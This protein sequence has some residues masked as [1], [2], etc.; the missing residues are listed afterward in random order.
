LQDGIALAL[1]IKFGE[2]NGAVVDEIRQIA[3]L[4]TLEAIM[5]HIE[6]APSLDAVR[7]FYAGG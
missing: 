6:A 3:D 7:Q 2:A 4:A 5:A 1:R